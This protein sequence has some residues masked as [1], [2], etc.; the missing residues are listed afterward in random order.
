[1][2]IDAWDLVMCELG[3]A[4]AGFYLS[5]MVWK[6]EAFNFA[7]AVIGWLAADLIIMHAIRLGVLV[8]K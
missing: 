8:G 7:F 5:R 4:L 6:Q 2:K 3:Y 1:M